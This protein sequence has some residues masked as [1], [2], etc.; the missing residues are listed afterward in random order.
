MRLSIRHTTRY[1]YDPP[2][3]RLALRLRLYPSRTAAQTPI[4]WSVK[5][6]GEDPEALLMNAY[7][8]EESIWLSHDGARE[9]EIVAEGVVDTSDRAGVLGDWQMAARPA[10]LL[11][12]TK[13]TAPSE[14]IRDLAGEAMQAESGLARAHSLSALVREAV[15]YKPGATT[16]GTTADEALRLGQGVCQDHAHILISGLRVLG[17][18]ARYVVGYLHSAGDD[19]LVGD[20]TDTHAWC[21]AWIEGLGWVG[22]DATNQICPTERYVRLASGLDAADAAPLRGAVT[23]D[24]EETLSAEV[25]VAVARGGQ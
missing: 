14:L 25:E 18:P 13:L 22:F 20:V 24:A 7:G 6:N 2:A 23:G 19:D 10:M 8:D 9:A 16:A 11:R 4:E 12:E 5:V 17:V 3:T 1:E 15:E 21:E